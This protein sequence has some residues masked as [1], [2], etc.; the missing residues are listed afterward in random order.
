[1]TD[2]GLAASAVW[3]L[4]EPSPARSPHPA[5]PDMSL[6]GTSSKLFPSEGCRATVPLLGAGPLSPLT[7]LVPP[8]DNEDPTPRH[9]QVT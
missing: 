2:P 6:G 8:R 5:R 1:M 9:T 7:L 4:P 3:P